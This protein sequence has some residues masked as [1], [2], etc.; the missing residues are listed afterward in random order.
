MD[1]NRDEIKEYLDA[2]YIGL[3]E[4]CWHINEF[5]MHLE[6]PHVYCLPVHL[7]DQQTV[8][9]NAD[10]NIYEVLERRAS[11]TTRLTAWFEANRKYEAACT[12]TYQNF[13]RTW[14]YNDKKKEW[15]PRMH[16]EPAVGRMYFASPSQGERFYLRTL[17]TVVMGATSFQHLRTVNG[18]VHN[19]FKQA[20][21]ALGL[22]QNDQEWVQCLTEAAEMQL[23]SSL[24]SLFATIL[25]HCNP[26][27][28]GNLW[29]QFRHHI[30][31][32]LRVK[33]L[34]IYPNREFTDDEVYMYGLHLINQIL[35]KSD[36][37]LSRYP[38]MPAIAGNWHINVPENR[39]LH[40]QRDYDI[41]QLAAIV[42]NN[43]QCFNDDQRQFYNT[44][45]D[46]VENNRGKVM[47]LHSAGG[48]EKTFVCNTIA[49]AVHAQGKIALCVASSGIASLLLDGGRTAH[50][51]F[52]IPFE[53]D[54]ASTCN[55]IRGSH[56][57]QL[58][59]QTSII[60][61]DEVPMQHR[62][63]TD[64]VDCTLRDL[65]KMNLPLG[66]ITALFG[67]DF[68]QTLP[69]V[70]RGTREQIIAASIRRSALWQRMTVHHLHHYERLE[71]TPENI[72]HAAW[73]L[74]IGSG[75]TVDAG[76]T[77]AIPQHML[78]HENTMEALINATYPDFGQPHPDQ[79][80]LDR[81]ILSCTN[82]NVDDINSALLARFPGEELIFNSA[83]TVSYR[84]QEQLNNYQ[85]YPTE[86]LNSLKVG[87]LPL[88]RLAL[89]NGCP[90][91]LL[92]NLD[93][94]IGL[95][96]GTQLILIEARARVLKCRIIS[97]DAKFAGN[98]VLIPRITLEPSAQTLPLP[99]QQHQ[100]P[101]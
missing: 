79:Y 52:K 54:E 78:L 53:L 15:G 23:G 32:D 58:L 2:R 77:V 57:H 87:G 66:G 101:V 26:T 90:I 64:G 13:P 14:V 61:W 37:D 80:Y 51:M 49:A 100:F 67:G 96:N 40:E 70:P 34:A 83:D 27:S 48:C 44:V 62:Y 42:T 60:I 19:T 22:L 25:L 71:R 35:I 9:F 88:S 93:P 63:A 20:C 69:V 89:K 91:M 82:D 47:F 92:R 3:V 95:C 30:C 38:D 73:L 55:I 99:L 45:M 85:P 16:G 81:T 84:E 43:V 28:P 12:V 24:R 56:L 39:L 72:A 97:G 1:Q 29:N 7:E 17:L 41:N 76:G 74:D 46:S 5:A 36:K 18:I 59:E 6:S 8:Y 33:L 10:D 68:E 4:S 31:D 94:S 65:K 11:K 50:S 21:V 86:Y 75:R 98:V